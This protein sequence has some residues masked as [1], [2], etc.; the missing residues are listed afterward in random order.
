MK[1]DPLPFDYLPPVSLPH[2]EVTRAE[3]L[4]LDNELHFGDDHTQWWEGRRMRPCQTAA[5]AA[6]ERLRLVQ[7]LRRYSARVD[8][9][10][11]AVARRL[12]RCCPEF[13]CKSGAC[14][15]CARAWQ[16]WFTIET[17]DFFANATPAGSRCMILSPVHVSGIVEPGEGLPPAALHSVKSVVSNALTAAG[18]ATA[19]TGIDVSFN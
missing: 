11:R 2:P 12:E 4:V 7:R 5:E 8:F 17:Q 18:L 6:V 1:H 14:P 16:R 13:R 3:W 19:V 15:E 10:A 9:N